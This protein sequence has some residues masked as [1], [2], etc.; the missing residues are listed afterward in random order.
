MCSIETI[1]YWQ[2]ITQMY[3]IDEDGHPFELRDETDS[4][5]FRCYICDDCGEELADFN[6]VKEHLSE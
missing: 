6:R 1:E 3:G 4:G 2:D 5:D